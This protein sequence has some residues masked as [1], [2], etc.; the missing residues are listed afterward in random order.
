MS[1]VILFFRKQRRALLLTLFAVLL[2]FCPVQQTHATGMAV[3]DIQAILT[4]I[5]NFQSTLQQYQ[6]QIQQWT[7]EAQRIATAAKA[8]SEGQYQQGIQGLMASANSIASNISTYMG[9]STAL[10]IMQAINA[11]YEWGMDMRDFADTLSES[12]DKLGALFGDLDFS[13]SSGWDIVND[14]LNTTMQTVNTVGFVA[15]QGIDA[16]ARNTAVFIGETAGAINQAMG[17][18]DKVRELQEQITKNQQDIATKTS[19]LQRAIRNGEDATAQGLQLEIETLEKNNDML[20][21]Q[22]QSY[23]DK[24][25]MALDAEDQTTAAKAE[26]I[27]KAEAMIRNNYQSTVLK[28]MEQVAGDDETWLGFI[29]EVNKGNENSSNEAQ[30]EVMLNSLETYFNMLKTKKAESQENNQNQS[31]SF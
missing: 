26:Q 28:T 30:N 23:S 1:S 29:E 10:E 18:S 13:D 2:L 5:N 17:I 9:D 15:N 25:K 27:A 24:L 11:G 21:E 14:V 8:I 7:A 3:M 31:W 16:I 12:G 4:A 22:M 6:R 19:E 20:I